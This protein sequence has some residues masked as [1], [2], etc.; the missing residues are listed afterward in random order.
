MANL[1]LHGHIQCRRCFDDENNVLSLDA[2]KIRNDPGA[3][4]SSTPS[5]LVLGFSK[6]ATQRDIY[7]SG[8]FD[9]VAFGGHETRKNLSNILRK[10]NLL[11]QDETV[12]QKINAEETGF[13]FGS[14]IRCSVARYDEKR[15]KDKRT[16]VFA[17]SGSLI[18][19]SFKEIPQIINNCTHEFLIS[20][21]QSLKLIIMLGVTDSYIRSCRNL[22]HQFHPDGFRM[23]NEVAYANDKYVW[24]HVT[25]P[26]KGNGTIGAWLNAES[27]DL[28]ESSRNRASGNKKDLAIAA[29]RNCGLARV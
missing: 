11:R 12:D 18:T 7:C 4:G 17:T 8:D 27:D 3:W 23:I 1:P 13:A 22:M 16:E 28:K 24:V 29:I 10:V 19:K 14:L 9:D 5:I 21:P 15:S 2:W 6:G 26:S 20:L 25:H